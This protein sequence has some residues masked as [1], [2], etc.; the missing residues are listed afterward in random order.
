MS[1][2]DFSHKLILKLDP[3]KAHSIGI[4]GLKNGFFS[5]GRYMTKE[6]KTELFGFELDNPLGLA[7]GFDKN[8]ELVDTIRNYGFGWDEIGSVTY[9][10]SNGNDKPRLFRTGEG[11]LLNRMGLNGDPAIKIV[12][13]VKKY[14]TP[15]A[16]NITK[17]HD[18][19]IMGDKAIEDILKTYGLVVSELEPLNK[20]IYTVF[21]LSCPNIFSGKT[22]EELGP[23]QDLMIEVDRMKG[24]RPYLIKISPNLEYSKRKSIVKLADDYVSGYICSNT[25]LHNH[26][27]YGRG[28]L[29]GQD[30]YYDTLQT[31]DHMRTLTDKVIIGCGGIKNGEDAFKAFIFGADVVQAYSGFVF[32]QNAGPN[33]AHKLN[34]GLDR[35]RKK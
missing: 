19:N 4:F 23:L 25:L 5:P 35:L 12:K 20:L 21:N 14:R 28:G 30:I 9:H 17:T 7:A 31:I 34:E 11:S 1:F 33:F 13:R 32:G 29:S 16:L 3:E 18:P 24:V 22:F 6:S 2:G 27:K 8:G 10:G 15:Y 26:P